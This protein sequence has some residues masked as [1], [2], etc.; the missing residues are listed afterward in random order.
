MMNVFNILRQPLDILSHSLQSQA[1]LTEAK[2][3]DVWL[4]ILNT[5]CHVK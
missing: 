5:K 2:Q 3:R 4:H 1:C